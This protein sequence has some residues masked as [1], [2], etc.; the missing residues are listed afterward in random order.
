MV[1]N[2]TPASLWQRRKMVYTLIYHLPAFSFIVFLFR[3][4]FSG[5]GA[6]AL[7]AL[8]T[9]ASSFRGTR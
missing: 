7:A 3:T 2:A 4:R 8:T 1:L 6:A 5:A 9:Q